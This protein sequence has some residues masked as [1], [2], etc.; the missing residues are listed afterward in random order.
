MRVVAEGIETQEVLTALDSYD[1]D[2]TQGYFVAR[3]MPSGRLEAWLRTQP[4]PAPDV[5]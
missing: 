3:P 5:V 2:L 1:C 4:H